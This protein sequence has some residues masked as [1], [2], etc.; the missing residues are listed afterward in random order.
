MWH[1]YDWNSMQAGGSFIALLGLSVLSLLV[2]K[3]IQQYGVRK[4]A[5]A[6]YVGT[7]VALGCLLFVG[8]NSALYQTFLMILLVVAGTFNLFLEISS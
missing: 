3:T 2:R 7:G 6:G 8:R 5:I 1:I 4:S